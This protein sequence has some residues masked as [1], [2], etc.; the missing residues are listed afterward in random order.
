MST[1]EMR[2][3]PSELS[4]TMAEMRIWLDERRVE[5]STFSCR[6][7]GA[8]VFVRVDFR[9]TEEAKA[10]ADRFTGRIGG[11]AAV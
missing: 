6:G 4:G 5:P 10:F 8:D 11:R 2:L 9:V 1:V 3:H 7:N